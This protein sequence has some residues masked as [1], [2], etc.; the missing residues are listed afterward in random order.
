MD[1]EVSISASGKSSINDVMYN[2]RV[3]SDACTSA[4]APFSVL[5]SGVCAGISLAGIT[6]N[7]RHISCTDFKLESAISHHRRLL[8]NFKVDILMLRSAA[9]LLAALRKFPMAFDEIFELVHIANN[10]LKRLN[11]VNGYM[12]TNYAEYIP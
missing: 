9:A 12:S 5:V 8:Q 2:E 4:D 3:C 1:A 7:Q 6:H 10:P 11:K